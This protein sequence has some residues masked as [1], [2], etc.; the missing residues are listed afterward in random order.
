MMH[1][2]LIVL[3]LWNNF[4]VIFKLYDSDGNGKVT[5][6]DM[7]DVLQDLTG[8]FMSEQQREVGSCPLFAYLTPLVAHCSLFHVMG[9]KGQKYELSHFC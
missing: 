8:Q 6:R 7:L 4:L 3:L 9:L 1:F 2:Y 5:F